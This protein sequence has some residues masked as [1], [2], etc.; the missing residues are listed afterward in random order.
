VSY[1]QLHFRLQ[2]T[3]LRVS[4]HAKRAWVLLA[5]AVTANLALL[6]YYK[7]SNFFVSAWDQVSGADWQLSP[8]LLPVYP[9][10]VLVDTYQGLV[11][12]YKSK[13]R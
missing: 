9:D 8:I 3:R 5:V 7:Y 6:A 12:E 4:G 10:R 2:I 1:L 11:T 13:W